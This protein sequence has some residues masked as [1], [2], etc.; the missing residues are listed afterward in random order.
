MHIPKHPMR[1]EDPADIDILEAYIHKRAIYSR[2][3]ARRIKRA[4]RK[5]ILV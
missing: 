4:L 1:Y 2:S 3:D 5:A